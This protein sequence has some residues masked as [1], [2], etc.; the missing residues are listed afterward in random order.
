MGPVQRQQHTHVYTRQAG[1]RSAL[2]WCRCCREALL[3]RAPAVPLPARGTS[4]PWLDGS[5]GSNSFFSLSKNP[6]SRL[7]GRHRGGSRAFGLCHHPC[8]KAMLILSLAWG[9]KK[10]EISE[11]RRRRT[12]GDMVLQQQQTEQS[13]MCILCTRRPPRSCFQRALCCCHKSLIYV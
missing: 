8:V 3:V 1:G 13:K 7:P 2:T 4:W 12:R 11:G 6:I 5:S 10:L 9:S